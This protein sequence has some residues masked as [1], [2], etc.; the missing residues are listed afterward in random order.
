MAKLILTM[1]GFPFKVPENSLFVVSQNSSTVAVLRYFVSR[2]SRQTIQTFPI[3]GG[4]VY[5]QNTGRMAVDTFDSWV[6]GSDFHWL[7][8]D[9]F[10]GVE[11]SI[12]RLC[13]RLSFPSPSKESLILRLPDSRA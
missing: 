13:V 9:T 3:I 10:M 4:K 1:T 11:G 8:V 12:E 6:T 7:V 5:L 2:L